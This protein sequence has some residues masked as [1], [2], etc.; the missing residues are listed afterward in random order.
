MAQYR[1]GKYKEALATLT[2][3]D[4][5]GAGIP[6][7]LAFLA[8]THHQLGQ[9]EQAQ[10]TFARFRETLNQPE[11]TQNEDLHALRR[12]AEKLLS[13]KPA[14]PKSECCSSLSKQLQLAAR[15]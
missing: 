2:Q 5:K 13:D 6:A 4:A 11:W 10:A 14:L 7:H 15:R 9:P 8:M 3:A 12:E 1:L